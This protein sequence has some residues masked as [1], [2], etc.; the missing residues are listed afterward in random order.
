M[1]A[2]AW[3]PCPCFFT[4]PRAFP[5]SEGEMGTSTVDEEPGPASTCATLDPVAVLTE[6]TVTGRGRH[7]SH[8]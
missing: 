3:A 5:I 1:A 8:C 7:R 2:S 4:E 6:F